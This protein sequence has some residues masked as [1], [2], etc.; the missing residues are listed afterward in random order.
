MVLV[1]SLASLLLGDVVA[2]RLAFDTGSGLLAARFILGVVP[3][4]I[5]RGLAH[6]RPAEAEK[7]LQPGEAGGHDL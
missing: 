4:G 1:L 7:L 5:E 6:L 3:P 2:A